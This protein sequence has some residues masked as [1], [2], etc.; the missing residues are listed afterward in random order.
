MI[1]QH[2]PDNSISGLYK[3]IQQNSLGK[4]GQAYRQWIQ[5]VLQPLNEKAADIIFKHTDLLDSSEM[6]PVLLKLIA[7]VMTL[8]VVISRW[9]MGDT[10]TWSVISYPDDILPYISK[11]FGRIK[12]KQAQLLGT[13]KRVKHSH[14]MPNIHNSLRSKL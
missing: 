2:S 9:K 1:Q 13:K 3:A 6:E 11:E 8:K 14:G 5:G 4:E 12:Q 7:H 10:E